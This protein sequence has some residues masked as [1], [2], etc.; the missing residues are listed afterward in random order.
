MLLR[1][2]DNTIQVLLENSSQISVPIPTAESLTNWTHGKLSWVFF[3][4]ICCSFLSLS[5]YGLRLERW[6]I[7]R[8]ADQTGLHYPIFFNRLFKRKRKH[9]Q[10]YSILLRF[11]WDCGLFDSI[12]PAERRSFSALAARVSSPR[13][14]CAGDSRLDPVQVVPAGRHIFQELTISPTSRNND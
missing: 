9:E 4:P 12:H 2:Y 6:N 7:W 10:S 3:V 14:V 11:W 5:V 8:N 1:R 13:G